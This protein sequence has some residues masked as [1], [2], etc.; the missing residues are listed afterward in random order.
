M[1]FLLSIHPAI[2]FAAVPMVCVLFA[3]LGLISV[4]RKFHEEIL[5]QNHE[6]AGFIFN[7][8]GLLY[9]VLVAFVVF[10]TWGSYDAAKKNIEMEVNKVADLFFDAAALDEQHRKDV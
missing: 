2:S 6:V 9:A 3:I 7:A 8:F 10:A 5:K 1:K 4:R